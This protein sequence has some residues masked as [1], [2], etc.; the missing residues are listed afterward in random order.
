VLTLLMLTVSLPCFAADLGGATFLK[1]SAYDQ[2]V[3]VKTVSGEMQMLGVGD[4]LDENTTILEILENRVVLK[5]PGEYAPE[6]VVVYLDKNGKQR[7]DVMS[8]QPL[9]ASEKKVE[10][11]ADKK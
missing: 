4:M 7:V 6:K 2:K 5:R 11:G 1:I 8:R 3:V 10:K 9:M